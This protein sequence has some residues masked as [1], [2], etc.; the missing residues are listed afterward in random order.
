MLGQ[1]DF[2][3]NIDVATPDDLHMAGPTSIMIDDT[4][5]IL[6]ATDASIG[7]NNLSNNRIVA[8]DIG[9]ITNGESEMAEIGQADFGS[10]TP[11][12]SQTGIAYPFGG[13]YDPLSHTL[14]ISEL[15][16][17]RVIIYK[18]LMI[19]KETLSDSTV[20]ADYG[21]LTESITTTNV[22]DG[23]EVT[24]A[25]VDPTD[26]SEED[27]SDLPPG[28][29]LNSD[30]T[31]TGTPTNA[32]TYTFTVKATEIF[33]YS[34]F[35]DTKEYT[36]II[37]PAITITTSATLTGGT[38]GTPYSKTI[39]TADNDGTV[40]CSRTAGSLPGGLTLATAS[41]NCTITG[42]PT[43]SGNFT[44]TIKVEDSSNSYEQSFHLNIASSGGGGGGGGGVSSGG[45]YTNPAP[46][47]TPDCDRLEFTSTPFIDVEG[48][49]DLD[50]GKKYGK[51]WAEP[52]I[53]ELYKNCIV[54]G[55]TLTLFAP[56]D[57]ITRAELL[58]VVMNRNKIAQAN[59]FESIFT[60]VIDSDWFALYVTKG[61]KLNIIEGYID[62]PESKNFCKNHE[63]GNPC[64]LPGNSITRAEAL[65]VILK[66]VDIDT[67]AYK[68]K[69]TTFTDVK[70]GDWFNEYVSFAAT[71]TALDFA[72]NK[73]APIINGYKNRNGS[74][75]FNPS[76]PITRSEA[77]K[78][79]IA[80]YTY[81]LAHPT[82]PAV[83]TAT[84]PNV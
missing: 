46:T 57:K 52:Y 45:S 25:A 8:F 26:F 71:N 29:E 79:I 66:T 65:K 81:K 42:T 15:E 56:Q 34:T 75:F 84:T 73:D 63:V 24:Y 74:W 67:T 38:Q 59:V 47:P 3:S 43:G 41:P 36:I 53:L 40:T 10:N 28:I 50:T 61:F 20:G 60:D 27:A 48:G 6:Y 12:T 22:Q 18:M 5:K 72:T 4:N 11:E 30:G 55:K 77:S 14:Y 51:D 83:S 39:L 58:K 54:D 80:V 33:G 31:L 78:I 82:N 19:D 76:A 13:S 2:A 23:G 68:Y 44:F 62:T 16:N 17:H 21:D 49:T 9:N 1:A 69:L 32:G 37:N 64:F 7:D 35:F 70:P